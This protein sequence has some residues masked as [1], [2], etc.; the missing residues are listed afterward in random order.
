MSIG[1]SSRLDRRFLFRGAGEL[2]PILCNSHV[3][4]LIKLG[5]P[6][7]LP[8]L[9]R[10]VLQVVLGGERTR[11]R[12]GA[13]ETLTIIEPGIIGRLFSGS[14]VLEESDTSA[15]DN[16]SA[17]LIRSSLDHMSERSLSDSHIRHSQVCFHHKLS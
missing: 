14:L 8:T 1:L 3:T 17:L 4:T 16:M 11:E 6:I 15:A 9:E 10:L 2:S 5:P 7:N 12:V 13:G